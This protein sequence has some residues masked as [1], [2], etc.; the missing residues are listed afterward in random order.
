MKK[1]K[2]TLFLIGM[3]ILMASNV[4][5]LCLNP[6][7]IL[8]LF[9]WCPNQITAVKPTTELLSFNIDGEEINVTTYINKDSK[10]KNLPYKKCLIEERKFGCDFHRSPP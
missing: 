9:E 4:N 3:V 1:C 7:E 5:A 8:P 10:I 2:I 6:F